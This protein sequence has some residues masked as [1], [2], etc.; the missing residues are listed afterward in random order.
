MDEVEGRIGLLR[1]IMESRSHGSTCRGFVCRS[2]DFGTRDNAD[3]SVKGCLIVTITQS[4]GTRLSAIFISSKGEDF[5]VA[6]ITQF[7]SFQEIL[8]QTSFCSHTPT[9]RSAFLPFR[10]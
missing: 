5:I 2:P 1:K 6:V 8:L 9:L 4:H 10:S 3:I 7:P